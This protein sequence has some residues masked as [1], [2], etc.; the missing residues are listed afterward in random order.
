MFQQTIKTINREHYSTEQLDIWSGQAG[1]IN[2]LEQD[3]TFVATIQTYIVG[4]ITMKDD[5]LIDLLYVHKNFQRQG[6]ATALL[7]AV[8]ERAYTLGLTALQ[9]EASITAEPFFEVRGFHIV[10]KQLKKV[11][12]IAYT[13]YYMT[14]SLI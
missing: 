11:Q 6:V 10:K 1:W 4:F 14:K 13:N 8:E 7:K 3:V 2:R 12:E 9:T 5:G